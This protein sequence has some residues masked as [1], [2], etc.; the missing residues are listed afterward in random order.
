MLSRIQPCLTALCL[1]LRHCDDI[2]SMYTYIYIS[3][4][5]NNNPYI[6][7]QKCLSY[8]RFQNMCRGNTFPRV[9][10]FYCILAFLVYASLYPSTTRNKTF[11]YDWFI[12][13]HKQGKS[14]PCNTGSK[15]DE[16]FKLIWCV[17]KIIIK[18]MNQSRS[19]YA[20][21]IPKFYWMWGL[22]TVI[23]N[24]IWPRPEPYCRLFTNPHKFLRLIL[25]YP[26]YFMLFDRFVYAS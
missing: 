6:Y 2:I 9:F 26:Q 11:S 1:P 23:T 8:S 18:S 7:L 3:V 21:E 15:I 24:T 4:F 5:V 12:M 20:K 13:P 16:I 17:N 10:E 14:N 25:S 22:V 19:W